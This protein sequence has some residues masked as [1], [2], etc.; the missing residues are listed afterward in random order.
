MYNVKENKNIDI[1]K[2]QDKNPLVSVIISTY[3]VEKY[4]KQC[5]DSLINQTYKNI[6]IICVDGGST[7]NTISILEFLKRK[8]GRI[9][10]IVGEKLN[11]AAARK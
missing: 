3:N 10:L 11:T 4:V 2:I 6:E 1:E 8:D 9:T 7:D 5:V